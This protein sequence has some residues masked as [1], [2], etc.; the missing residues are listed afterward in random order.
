[1]E[2]ADKFNEGDVLVAHTTSPDWEP[3]MKKASA[4]ITET[5]GRT[6]HAAIVSRELGKPAIVG[7]KNAMK[8]LNEDQEVTVSC[9]EGEIGKVYEGILKYEIQKVDISKLPRPKTKIMMNLGNPEL[10]FL[11]QNSGWMV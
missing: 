2:E 6:C 11:W 7:A 4:V 10:A 9:A 3:V 8:I 1:M 5:G